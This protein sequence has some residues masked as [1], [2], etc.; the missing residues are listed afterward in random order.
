MKSC[1]AA[2]R[3]ESPSISVSSSSACEAEPLP[4]VEPPLSTYRQSAGSQERM[5]VEDDGACCDDDDRRGG[6][7]VFGDDDG[8]FEFV[9]VPLPPP[10]CDVLPVF[11]V[12]EFGACSPE[13]GDIALELESSA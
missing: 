13:G 4:D 12:V 7:V 6:E 3:N 2:T 8:V 11:P 10:G 5:T 1:S 9:D